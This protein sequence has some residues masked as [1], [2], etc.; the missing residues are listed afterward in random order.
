[1]KSVFSNISNNNCYCISL[2]VLEATV[3]NNLDERR[4]LLER[5]VFEKLVMEATSISDIVIKLAF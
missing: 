3:Q 2:L 1:M 5:F 4:K